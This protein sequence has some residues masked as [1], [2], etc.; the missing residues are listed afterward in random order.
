MKISK[1][2][3]IVVAA[4]AF[5]GSATTAQEWPRL[6][7]PPSTTAYSGQAGDR[8]H[9]ILAKPASAYG[10]ITGVAVAERSDD[11][12]FLELMY[13]DVRTAVAQPSLT[14][15]ECS[16]NENRS[17]GTNTSRKTATVASSV[18]V[19]GVRICLN[20]DRTKMKGIQ[21]IGQFSGCIMGEET[22]ELGGSPCTPL[23]GGIEYNPCSNN[24]PQPRT[25]SCASAENRFL[26]YP[27]IERTNCQGENQGPDEDWEAE[28]TCPSAMVA[29]GM[30]L[31]TRPGG[32][33]RRMIDGV[34]LECR[35]LATGGSVA[36]NP[37]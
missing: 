4:S 26:S 30:K 5:A 34:A 15:A 16:D 19:T 7:D 20:D 31:N 27:P 23:G 10:T 33:G 37:G 11:P 14:F 21:L 1:A 12:C 24:P 17:E 3:P 6:L 29:T 32:G 35:R 2:M 8:G 22:F 36:F 13:R 18:L 9:R 25:V 28:V